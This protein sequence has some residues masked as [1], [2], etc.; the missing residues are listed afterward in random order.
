MGYQ[1]IFFILSLF[2]LQ[3][4]LSSEHI[5]DFGACTPPTHPPTIE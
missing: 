2:G 4:G 5:N 1:P 3:C